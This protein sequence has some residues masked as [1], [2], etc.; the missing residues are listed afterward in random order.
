M[1]QIK[2]IKEMSRKLESLSRRL[3]ELDGTHELSLPE[4]FP[5][6]FM[7]RHT[8]FQTIDEMMDA[9]EFPTGSAEDFAAIPDDEW[10]RYVAET[11]QFSDWDEMK[12]AAAKEWA[13]ARL[14]L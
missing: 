3:E 9:S 6:R 12:G 14:A 4:L 5:P 1:L 2:G 7:S 11:T 8:S 10:D 13:S